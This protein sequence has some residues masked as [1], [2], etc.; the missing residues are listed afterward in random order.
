MVKAEGG[1]GKRRVEGALQVP[2]A[3]GLPAHKRTSAQGLAFYPQGDWTLEPHAIYWYRFPL[4]GNGSLST[5]SHYFV[6][7]LVPTTATKVDG[8]RRAQST[9]RSL[10]ITASILTQPSN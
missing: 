6:F 10:L 2:R 1:R 3:Q 8:R 9:I 4:G 5:L 7:F